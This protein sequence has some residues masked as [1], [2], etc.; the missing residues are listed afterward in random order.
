MIN[1]TIELVRKYKHIFGTDY[2]QDANCQAAWLMT[3]GSGGTTAD[4]S[5]NGYTLDFV[6][7]SWAA[8]NTESNAPSY[9]DFMIVFDGN[10]DLNTTT[11]VPN[12]GGWTGLATG[13]WVNYDSSGSDEHSIISNFDA[14]QAS[15]LLRLEPSN[16]SVEGFIIVQADTQLGGTFNDTTITNNQWFHVYITYDKTSLKCYVNGVVDTTTFASSANLDAGNSALRTELGDSPHTPGDNLTGKMSETAIF[17][18][19]LD[20]TEVNDI[21]D[22]GLL[23][24]VVATLWD[25]THK[26]IVCS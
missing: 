25:T 4:S 12:M 6:N 10:D 18:R 17:D 7:P 9:A 23:G 2:T 11:T 15:V 24:A 16:D 21:M 22:N 5:G 14:D 1:N 13:G 8:M 3:E 19:N 26:I 20:S